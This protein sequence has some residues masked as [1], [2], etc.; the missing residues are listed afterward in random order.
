MDKNDKLSELTIVPKSVLLHLNVDQVKP[1]PNNPRRLFD[2]GPLKELRDS[3]QTHGVLVPITVYKLP[4]QDKYA[5]VDGERRYRCCLGLSKEGINIQIPA[6]MVEAPNKIASL[7]YMFNIHA[8]RE[9]WELMPTALSVQ[10]VINELG[11]EDTTELYEITG[12]SVS[13]IG[14]CK[15]IL[16]FPKKFQ[17]LSLQPNPSERIPSNFWVELYP[18]LENA[19]NLIPDLYLDLGRDGITE[20]MVGK[21]RDKKVVSVIHFRR[22]LEAIEIATDEGNIQAVADRLREFI[23]TPEMETRK[24][25]DGFIQDTKK[26][27]RAVGICEKFIKDLQKSKVDYAIEEKEDVIAMLIEVIDF[28]QKLLDKLQ[29][30]EP[31]EE[32]EENDGETT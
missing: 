4:G 29:G 11:I 15:K 3:I 7:I 12:L 2:P 24:A 17:D 19:N 26:I 22:I 18:V 25:F 30:G 27:Q 28:S 9:E 31:P 16:S 6:N 8:F 32:D 10:E 13:Q 21:Y 1:N 20:R 14:K 23:L 5:I